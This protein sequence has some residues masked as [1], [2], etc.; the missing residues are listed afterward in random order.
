M[1]KSAVVGFAVGT[2]S[3]TTRGTKQLRQMREAAHAMDEIKSFEQRHKLTKLGRPENK[4]PYVQLE[5]H[6]AMGRK[7]FSGQDQINNYVEA[8]Q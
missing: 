6:Y 5:A 4:Y 7:F 2:H 3:K 1:M 8:D